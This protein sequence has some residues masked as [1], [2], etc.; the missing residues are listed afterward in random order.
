MDRPKLEVADVWRRYG[1]AYREQHAASLS[2][3]QRQ[4]MSAIELCRT[5]ALGSHREHC[6]QCPYER[7]CYDSCRNRRGP[8]CRALA[9]AQWIGDRQAELLDAQYCHVVFPLPE[10]IAAIA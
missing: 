2:T 6:D 7:T 5:D 10:E 3:A 4:V 9:R 1:E 8:K